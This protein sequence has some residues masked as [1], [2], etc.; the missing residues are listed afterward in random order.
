MK[1]KQKTIGMIVGVIILVLFVLILAIGPFVFGPE[2]KAGDI[3]YGATYSTMYADKLGIDPIDGFKAIVQD[4]GVT[5]VRVPV[6]WDRIEPSK[7]VFV[8]DE[9]DVIMK[10]AEDND[11]D[12]V[13]AIGGRVPRWPECFFPSWAR[14]LDRAKLGERQL[15]MV[16]EVVSRYKDS[17]SLLRWQVENEPFLKWFGECPDVDVDLLN[18]E[19]ELVKRLDPSHEIMTTASGE[20]SMWRRESKMTPSMIGTSVYRE[21]H[22]PI[23]GYVTYPIPAWFYVA[24]ASMLGD[25]KVIVSELQAEPWFVGDVSNYEIADQ[26]DLF[27]ARDLERNVS[28]ANKIGFSEVYV[29][30]V[31]WW[32]F[33]KMNGHPELWDAG[34]KI[35]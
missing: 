2:T 18:K 9:V 15:N 24:K 6:Y 7:D 16:D 14:D 17:N 12:V 1:N 32:Y 29:W 28:Y 4:L 23:F 35:F 21:V 3:R 31:E 11:V 25:T 33:M 27:T 22:N 19:V 8:W 26:V 20:Q 34:R 10:I 30:G 13:L 5:T